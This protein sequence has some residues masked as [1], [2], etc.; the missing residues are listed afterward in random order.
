M[1]FA[2]SM[3]EIHLKFKCGSFCIQIS[4]LFPDIMWAV[5]WEDCIAILGLW[6]S[7]YFPLALQEGIK[8]GR[9]GMDGEEKEDEKKKDWEQERDIVCIWLQMIMKYSSE[10]IISLQFT[11]VFEFWV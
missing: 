10:N 2:K 11:C 8:R 7:T 6:I 3:L 5:L 9:I 4:C 1:Q